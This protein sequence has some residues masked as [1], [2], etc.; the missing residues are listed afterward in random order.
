MIIPLV[1]G[2][3]VGYAIRGKVKFNFELL[4]SVTLVTLILLMGMKAGNVKVDAL[5][6]LSYSITL[7][8]T[9]V[10]GSVTLAKIMWRE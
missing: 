5:K 6:I 3:V 2:I 10:V 9:S 4:M 7:A 1:L 8:L